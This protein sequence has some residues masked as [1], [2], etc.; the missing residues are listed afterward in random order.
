MNKKPMGN[1][2]RLAYAKAKKQAG[3]TIPAC[4]NYG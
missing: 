3:K 1:L 4:S 2:K